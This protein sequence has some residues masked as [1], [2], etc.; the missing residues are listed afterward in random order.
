H[1]LAAEGCRVTLCARTES[2]L[3][4]AAAE[5]ARTAGSADRVLAG[6]AGGSTEAGAGQVVTRTVER[7]GGVDVVVNN[8]SMAGGRGLL[9]TSDAEWQESIDQA[10]GTAVRVSRLAVPHMQRAGGGASILIS[11]VFGC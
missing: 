8:V 11:A 9:D 3:R 4:D 7:F 5:G 1:A 10:L 6:K 2:R